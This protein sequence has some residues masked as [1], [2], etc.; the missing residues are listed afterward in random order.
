MGGLRPRTP[1]S[2]RARA[3]QLGQDVRVD[4]AAGRKSPGA[5][6]EAESAKVCAA[7][8]LPAKSEALELG[9]ARLAFGIDFA[10][11]EGAALFFVAENLIGGADLGEP[12]LRPRLLA[13]IGMVLLGQFAKSGLDFGRAG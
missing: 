5:K 8:R 4:R 3:E 10:A 11:V 7:A 13:L 12:L 9:R 1:S 6:I 2:T